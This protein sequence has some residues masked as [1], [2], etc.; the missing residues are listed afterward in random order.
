MFASNSGCTG[1]TFVMRSTQ[2]T[3]V[4]GTKSACVNGVID[5]CVS[6]VPGQ[7]SG[8]VSLT[9]YPTNACSGN[10]SEIL[11]FV[12]GICVQF[13]GTSYT[14]GCSNGFL[15]ALYFT[16]T[17]VCLGQGYY[18]QFAGGQ[19]VATPVNVVN[20][21]LTASAYTFATCTAP[22]FHESTEIMYDGKE[23]ITLDGI[24]S[25]KSSTECSSPHVLQ[26]NGVSIETSCAVKPLR[27]TNDH[28]VYTSTGLRTAVSL[29]KG[30]IVYSDIEQ[31]HQCAVKSVSGEYNQKYF[32]LNC[33]NS[34]V[35]ADGEE[36]GGITGRVI[37]TSFFRIAGV[38]TSTFGITH[39]IPATWMKYGSKLL[40]VH[41]ASQW[42]EKVVGILGYLN[43]I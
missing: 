24:L 34:D 13:L 5:E 1:N 39:S 25:G 16:N 28:L 8:A 31:H 4:A 2:T 10:P 3:C 43:L 22:C 37:L 27:L 11:S 9:T 41:R 26:S 35:I 14:V 15:T 40:G 36:R 12:N 18:S 20:L 30:D 42:G 38:K 23:K 6:G 21:N 17:N 19:C 29:V 32:A 33:R 7:F